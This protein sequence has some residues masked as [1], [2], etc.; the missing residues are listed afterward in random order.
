M[1]LDLFGVRK[2]DRAQEAR[3]IREIQELIRTIAGNVEENPTEMA[4]LQAMMKARTSSLPPI[5]IPTPRPSPPA[6][7]VRK[8]NPKPSPFPEK[9]VFCTRCGSRLP[10]DG[11]G[12][13]RCSGQQYRVCPYCGAKAGLA[14]RYCPACRRFLPAEKPQRPQSPS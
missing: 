14:D 8:M 2:V 12:C 9:A 10:L 7:V 13:A 3:R 4:H 1:G 11:S 5:A 6:E